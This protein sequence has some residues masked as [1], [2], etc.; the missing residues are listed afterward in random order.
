M[1]LVSTGDSQGHLLGVQLGEV[2]R[3]VIG[4]C[5]ADCWGPVLCSKLRG[6]KEGQ[7]ARRSWKPRKQLADS[8]QWLHAVS[9]MLMGQG[10]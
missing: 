7:P 3:G 5:R 2:P 9:M 10:G 8:G 6:W 4:L 1:E